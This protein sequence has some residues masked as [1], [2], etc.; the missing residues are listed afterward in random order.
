MMAHPK[1]FELLTS[2]LRPALCPVELRMQ[3][4]VPKEGLEPPANYF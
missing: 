4:L 1:R 2:G 3:M